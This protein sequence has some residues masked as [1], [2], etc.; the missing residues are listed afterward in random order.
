MQYHHIRGC[1][2]FL[3]NHTG[4]SVISARTMDYNILVNAEVLVMPRKRHFI[5]SLS[6]NDPMMQWTSKYGFVATNVLHSLELTDGLN[7]KGLSVAQLWLDDTEY[8]DSNHAQKNKSIT[9][10]DLPT[11]ILGNFATV[12]E[13]INAIKNIT[14]IGKAGIEDPDT[15]LPVH[16]VIHDK[17]K[18]S[19][20]IEFVE[21]KAKIY[22]K[23]ASVLTNWPAFPEQIKHL[24]KCRNNK[25]IKAWALS[26]TGDTSSSA[27]RLNLIHMLNHFVA[28]SENSREA[29][30]N[31]LHIL[32]R[33][34]V[35]N[36][37]H[38]SYTHYQT[39]RDHKNLVYYVVDN[40][41][42]NLRGL[43]MKQLDFS[44]ER[45]ITYFTIA[46]ESWFLPVNSEL[47]PF[48]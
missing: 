28:K 33:V 26:V 38:P 48:Y 42:M 15:I 9:I 16:I 7:E 5:S 6:N 20:V 8:A 31:A 2:E 18:R 30:L 11:W 12:E 14:V 3:L 1:S 10:V 22:K 45:Q 43:D 36:G 27:N 17:D 23:Y 39:I 47:K 35:V 13:V 21:G 25:N 40:K 44:T 46:N 32:N 34:T 29:I 19:A 24:K 37:E 41:N 4:D